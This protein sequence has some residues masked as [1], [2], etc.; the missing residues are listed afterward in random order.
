VALVPRAE[1][2]LLFREID[3]AHERWIRVGPVHLVRQLRNHSV[4]G[5][6]FFALM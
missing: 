6:R 2:G 1:R 5:K 3:D 4:Y